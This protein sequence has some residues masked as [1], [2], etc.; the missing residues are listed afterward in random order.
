MLTPVQASLT[1]P[2]ECDLLTYPSNPRPRQ[3]SDD[4]DSFGAFAWKALDPSSEA[5]EDA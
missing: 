2:T 4:K 3:Q 1:S 5:R